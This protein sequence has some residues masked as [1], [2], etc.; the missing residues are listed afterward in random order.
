MRKGANA[1]N[2][3]AIIL[4]NIQIDRVEASILEIPGHDGIIEHRY[5][6]RPPAVQV[7]VLIHPGPFMPMLF[8]N[9]QD[10]GFIFGGECQDIKGMA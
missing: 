6:I 7:S 3:N 10:P 8:G 1:L 2:G 4:V 9:V 5:A